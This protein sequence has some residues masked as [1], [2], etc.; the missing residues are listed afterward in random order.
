MRTGPFS[1]TEVIERLNAHFVPVYVVNED[2]RAAGP[3]PKEERDE[4][5]RIYREAL[6]SGFSAGSVHVYLLAPNGK[7]IAGM[8]VAEAAQTPKLITLL[9]RAIADL[10]I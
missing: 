4:M 5:E 7:T 3:A 8:H 1:K 2:Y 10:Q 6:N 9:D